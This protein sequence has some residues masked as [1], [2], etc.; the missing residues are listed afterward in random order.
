[1]RSAV[2]TAAIV[3]AGHGPAALSEVHIFERVASEKAVSSRLLYAIA[4]A[5]SGRGGRPWPWTLNV[6]GRS[7]Y[8]P[9]REKAH[10]ELVR[11]VR[12][13]YRSIDVGYM[14]VNLAHHGARLGDTWLA[15]DPYRNISAAADILRENFGEA[16]DAGRAVAHYHSRTPWRA[17]RYLQ[18]VR[19]HYARVR[20]G[21]VQ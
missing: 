19:G 17:D 18:R 3:C 7:F 5:E 21:E 4:L 15:L 8:F 9:D 20:P 16:G 13:G 12:R 1:V 2:V 11:L 14:Q 6:A 10:A